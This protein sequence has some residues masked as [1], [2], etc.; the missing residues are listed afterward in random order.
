MVRLHLAA[1]SVVVVREAGGNVQILHVEGTGFA[2]GRLWG[3]I[4]GR[5]A[6]GRR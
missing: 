3:H 1:A 2:R 5:T 4:T 6:D